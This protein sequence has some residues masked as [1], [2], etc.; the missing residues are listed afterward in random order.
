MKPRTPS[1]KTGSPQA[2]RAVCREKLRV[3]VRARCGMVLKLLPMELPL[4]CRE[5]AAA[6]PQHSRSTA[7]AQP[8]HS[9]GYAAA[10][11]TTDRVPRARASASAASRIVV[12]SSRIQSGTATERMPAPASAGSEPASVSSTSQASSTPPAAREP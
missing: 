10:A 6:Q 11:Q 12:G 2:P 5:A 9:R 1:E 7:A 8:Q 4:S 3:D